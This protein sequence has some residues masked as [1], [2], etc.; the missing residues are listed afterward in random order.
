MQSCHVLY[1]YHTPLC[2]LNPTQIIAATGAQAA[3][4]AASGFAAPSSSL[5]GALSRSEPRRTFNFFSACSEILVSSLTKDWPHQELH[6]YISHLFLYGNALPNSPGIL[7]DVFSQLLVVECPLL[8]AH[9]HRV[10]NRICKFLGVPGV[11]D[12]AAVQ[13]LRRT[14]EL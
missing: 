1:P 7:V 13:A 2:F 4:W 11:D 6:S 9:C 8:C 12:D 10:V 14:S 5:L 3:A